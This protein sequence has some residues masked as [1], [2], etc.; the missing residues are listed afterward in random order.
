MHYLEE[1]LLNINEF[2]R[3]WYTPEVELVMTHTTRFGLD[4]LHYVTF[5]F[6][7]YYDFI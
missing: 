7:F 5:L 6:L 2:Q 3:L 1:H 4:L